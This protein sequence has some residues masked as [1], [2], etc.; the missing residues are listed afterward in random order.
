MRPSS[1]PDPTSFLPLRPMPLPKAILVELEKK[2]ER[3]S[4]E[5]SRVTRRDLVRT[6]LSCVGWCAFG[7]VIMGVGFHIYAL[8]ARQM[9]MAQ[10]VFYL[11]LIIGTAGPA[12]TLLAAYRRGEQRGDW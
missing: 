12:F 7:G 8:T 2:H 11:G 10:G 5:A 1:S 4:L 6:A 3:E 9:A